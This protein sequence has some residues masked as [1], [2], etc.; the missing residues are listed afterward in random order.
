MKPKYLSLTFLFLLPYLSWGQIDLHRGF[1]KK[2]IDDLYYIMG[3]ETNKIMFYAKRPYTKKKIKKE[4]YSIEFYEVISID[5]RKDSLEVAVT[6]SHKPLPQAPDT[7][8]V[9]AISEIKSITLLLNRLTHPPRNIE[10]DPLFY[11][12][13]STF[14]SGAS[15]LEGMRSAGRGQIRQ[16]AIFFATSI[17]FGLFVKMS[18]QSAI[19]KKKYKIAYNKWQISS[20][21]PAS[22]LKNKK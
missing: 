14:L 7:S 15:I 8:F 16:S 18:I 1:V 3:I 5:L 12:A 2:Q 22:V 19:N 20:P 17:V 11:I 9:F 21:S 4:Y 6:L 10:D 13:S